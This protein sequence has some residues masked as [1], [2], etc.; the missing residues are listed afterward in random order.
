MDDKGEKKNEKIFEK[1]SIYNTY[2]IFIL[3]RSKLC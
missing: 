1:Y 3:G 2:A